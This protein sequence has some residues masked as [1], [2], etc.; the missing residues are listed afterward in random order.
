MKVLIENE[1]EIASE[2][3][4][5]ELS[6][7]VTYTEQK[8]QAHTNQWLAD[9]LNLDVDKSNKLSNI[10]RNYVTVIVYFDPGILRVLGG[11][12]SG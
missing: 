11:C 1:H 5:A 2:R 12:K 8:I 7:S 3:L 6:E 4:R 9:R 10:W